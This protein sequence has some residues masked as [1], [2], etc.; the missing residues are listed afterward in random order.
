MPLGPPTSG[1]HFLIGR[2]GY[3]NESLSSNNCFS[4]SREWSIFI[5]HTFD[6]AFSTIITLWNV[7]WF[8][9]L[10][11]LSIMKYTLDYLVGASHI[12]SQVV[13]SFLPFCIMICQH[14][15]RF[16][17]FGHEAA[18]NNNNDVVRIWKSYHKQGVI[19]INKY[20]IKNKM[21]RNVNCENSKKSIWNV[22]ADNIIKLTSQVF[23]VGLS[24][25]F[26]FFN[27]GKNGITSEGKHKR[28]CTIWNLIKHCETSN[29]R[30]P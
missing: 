7:T 1:K 23:R 5:S 11:I 6:W 12:L 30:Y 10:S 13:A 28:F 15:H 19:M 29:K 4:L 18:W 8:A 16:T 17:T 20:L 24:F 27:S 21:S 25:L 9:R 26:Y 2:P 14:H 22:V 3:L